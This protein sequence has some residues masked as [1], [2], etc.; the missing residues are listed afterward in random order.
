MQGMQGEGGCRACKGRVGA[1]QGEGGCRA[2]KLGEGGA[3]K[4]SP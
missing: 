3:G 1:G 4:I 2:C